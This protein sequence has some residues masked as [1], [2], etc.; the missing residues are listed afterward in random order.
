MSNQA[1]QTWK[2][3]CKREFPYHSFARCLC[4]RLSQCTTAA[5]RKGN[6]IRCSCMVCA[7]QN[8]RH[9]QPVPLLHQLQRVFVEIMLYIIV[10]LTDHVNMP[11]QHG[12]QAWHAAMEKQSSYVI[13]CSDLMQVNGE[14]VRFDACMTAAGIGL[15]F[16]SPLHKTSHAYTACMVPG[17]Y[18]EVS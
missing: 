16:L 12:N 1:V 5:T 10:F 13:L 9:L 15:A 6:G 4:S 2:W 11:L 14:F 7:S 17:D 8:R 18:W 3:M